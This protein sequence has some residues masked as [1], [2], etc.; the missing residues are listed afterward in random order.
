MLRGRRWLRVLKWTSIG[1]SVGIVVLLLASTK[2]RLMR[3]GPLLGN[4]AI[5]D[6]QRGALYAFFEVPV[7]PARNYRPQASQ[8]VLISWH[9]RD[10][11]TPD[12][13]LSG[14]GMRLPEYKPAAPLQDTAIVI[15]LWMPLLASACISLILVRAGRPLPPGLCSRCR[16]NLTGNLSGIC[17]ECGTPTL[18]T[19]APLALP[20]PPPEHARKPPA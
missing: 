3:F 7:Q 18:Q 19:T 5:I 1:L 8:D 12:F 17:P 20:P 16:Y 6:V 15:P 2:Y 9:V 10:L 13:T 11:G 14:V 4:P